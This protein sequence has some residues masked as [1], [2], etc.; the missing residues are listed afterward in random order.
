MKSEVLIEM[1]RFAFDDP[2]KK[3][4]GRAKM[5]A[6]SVPRK[7]DFISYAGRAWEVMGI[8]FIDNGSVRCMCKE[9]EAP[10]IASL[11]FK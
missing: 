2:I 9:M 3:E 8:I 7:G 11:S 6:P 4:N 10:S 5:I 1:F